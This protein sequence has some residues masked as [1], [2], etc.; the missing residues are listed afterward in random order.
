LEATLA[1]TAVRPG[2]TTNIGVTANNIGTVNQSN[3]TI[4][5][6]KPAGYNVIA[7]STAPTS[8]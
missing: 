5:L 4:K 6:K 2:F 3:I 1:G 8:N 7:T